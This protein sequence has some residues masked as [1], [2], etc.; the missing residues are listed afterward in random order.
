MNRYIAI[1]YNNSGMPSYHPI[2]AKDQTEAETIANW[3][4][5]TREPGSGGTEFM[6]DVMLVEDMRHVVDNVA[7]EPTPYTIADTEDF[8][9]SDEDE[10]DFEE[11][12]T[13]EDN[14]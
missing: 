14:V 7:N 1:C 6:V 12:N 5:E 2:D 4:A 11:E 13:D 3:M 10:E 8:V 9:E